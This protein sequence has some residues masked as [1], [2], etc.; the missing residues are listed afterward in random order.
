MATSA[1][2]LIVDDQDANVLLLE[3]ILR[4]AGYTNIRGI[5]DSRLALPMV[6]DFQPDLILLDL[7]MPHVDG[8]A[9][10]ERMK[11]LI[12]EGTYLPILVLTADIT[13]EAKRRTLSMGAKDFLTKPFD[14]ME[15]LLR[16][17]NLLET[18]A[19]HLQIRDENVLLEHKVRER[20]RD[21][22]EARIEILARLAKAAEFRDD[23]TG[24]HDRRIG[25]LAARVATRI[26][27]PGEEV[28]LIRLAAPLHDVG[29]IGIPDNILLKPGPLT[30][31]EFTVMKTHTTI[32]AELLSGS[33]DPLLIRAREIALTHHEQ[34]DG[35]GYPRGLKEQAIPLPGRIV[36]VA[37]AYDSMTNDRPYRKARP[38]AEALEILRR[39]AGGQWD[40]SVVEA[41]DDIS[42]A[43]GS[44][45]SITPLG[46]PATSPSKSPQPFPR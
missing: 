36:A 35:R 32:G 12:D 37:D 34:W 3:E 6:V 16:V 17:Q 7:H 22:E 40:Q 45:H 43:R 29:K 4:E 9:F 20:T 23:V 27:L 24:Q 30:P 41:F 28:E 38:V 25:E 15:V 11:P 10:L 14:T 46:A 13:Q 44:I 31:D 39:G 42:R 5:T 8:F 21:L 19:L 18:R 26:G 1:Q 2:I 33:Q